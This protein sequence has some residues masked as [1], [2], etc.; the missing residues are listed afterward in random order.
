MINRK[1]YFENIVDWDTKV[2]KSAKWY[3]E[4]IFSLKVFNIKVKEYVRL[5]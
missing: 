2:H 4:N 3:F 5:I 1:E